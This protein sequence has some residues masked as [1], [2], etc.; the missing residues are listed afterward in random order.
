LFPDGRSLYSRN[1]VRCPFSDHGNSAA[2]GLQS[3]VRSRAKRRGQDKYADQKGTLFFD[4]A[5]GFERTCIILLF[6]F[7]RI[8]S[9]T[10]R[11]VQEVKVKFASLVRVCSLASAVLLAVM[12]QSTAHLQAQPLFGGM[13]WGTKMIITP[14]IIAHGGFCALC[15]RRAAEGA[16]WGVNRVES[17]IKISAAQRPAYDQLLAAVIEAADLN[18]GTC[19]ATIQSYPTNDCCFWSGGWRA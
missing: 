13:G 17:A 3:A 11:R 19:P 8:P 6:T 15:D 9:A 10:L 1:K 12:L 5:Q 2:S 4:L 18:N 16:A 7:L 14:V